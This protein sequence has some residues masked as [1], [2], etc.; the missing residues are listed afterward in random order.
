M[1]FQAP[2]GRRSRLSPGAPYRGSVGRSFRRV[3]I[4]S[5]LALLALTA[6]ANPPLAQEPR[7]D[8]APTAEAYIP[9]SPKTAAVVASPLPEID[10]STWKFGIDPDVSTNERLVA[11]LRGE[12]D[13][14]AEPGD[15]TPSHTLAATTILG[16]PTVALV[17]SRATDGWVRIMIPVRPNGSEG[18]VSADQ[19]DLYVVEGEIVIDLSD[20]TLTY[21]VDG[22]TLL[23]STVAIGTDR[24]PTPTGNFF[25]T[26]N[27]TLARADSPWGPHA[28]GLSARS[29]TI[30]EYNGGDGIIGVHGTNRPGSIGKAS[31]LGCIRL[32]NDLI[33]RLHELVPIGTP[34]EIRA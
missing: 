29:D 23:S 22:A 20:R 21:Q 28:L 27:V 14:F 31:S 1:R 16:T 5:V 7:S 34:V 12:L 9:P 25:V 4:A 26:D 13:A 3:A 30:T 8:H 6:C 32:P 17:T 11:R 33:T 24:N 10:G 2:P 19:I 18:W 15:A